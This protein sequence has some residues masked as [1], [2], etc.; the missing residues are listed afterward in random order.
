LEARGDIV[1]NAPAGAV[2]QPA[3]PQWKYISVKR[4]SLYLESSLKEGMQWAV[5]EPNGPTLWGQIRLNVG[6][7]LQALFV[8]GAFQGADS[9]QAYFVKCDAETTTQS[10]IDQGIVNVV[11]GFA[12]LY[13]A[14]FV[15]IEISQFTSAYRPPTLGK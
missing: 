12:P 11:V 9:Q 8:Q 3:V 13:P 7:F 2:P 5:F 10:N 6:A 14:E 1:R 15:T 4:M